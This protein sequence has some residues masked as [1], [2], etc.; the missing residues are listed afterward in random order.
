MNLVQKL[1]KFLDK[2]K[3]VA[4]KVL[5]MFLPKSEQLIAEHISSNI[6]KANKLQIELD[7]FTEK[8]ITD[9]FGVMLKLPMK[10]I[11]PFLKR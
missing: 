4:A 1:A 11:L 6:S 5:V 3:K 10:A 8:N 9:D 7:H 2:M